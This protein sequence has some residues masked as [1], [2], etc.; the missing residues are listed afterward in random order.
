ME[1]TAHYLT[2][3]ARIDILAIANGFTDIIGKKPD[4]VVLIII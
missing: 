3:Y 2:F 1:I 4:S